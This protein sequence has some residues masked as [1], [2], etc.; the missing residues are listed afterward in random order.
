MLLGGSVADNLFQI[1]SLVQHL[2][3]LVA[4]G[5]NY[6]RNTMSSR[7]E[8][9]EWSFLFIDSISKYDLDKWNDPY[10]SK[11]TYFLEETHK[12]DIIVQIEIWATFDYYR[13]NWLVNPFNPKNNINYTTDRTKLPI[14]IPT[15]P[16]YRDN[17]FFWSVP[18]M[19]NNMKLLQYQQRF[20]DRL[21]LHTLHYPH[22]LYC[23][24]N[25]TSVTGAWG[26]FWS[27]YIKKVAE[28][29]GKKIFTTEMWD[30]WDLDHLSHRESFDHPE[31]YD[32]VEISQNN[33]QRGQQHWDNGIKQI[34]KLRRKGDY[35][36]V[37]SV[38]VYGNEEGGHGG[39]S[40]NGIE[41]F[42]R[43]VFFGASAVR[44]HRPESGLGLDPRA[45]NVI[46]GMRMV[47][48]STDF[49]SGK[50]AQTIFVGE[51][52]N[53]AYARLLED[54]STL[55]YSTQAGA[56]ELSLNEMKDVIRINLSD[57]R[58]TNL[59]KQNISNLQATEQNVVFILR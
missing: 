45:Q 17:P 52:E 42:V 48:D 9:N 18:P 54:G 24:D 34:E 57:A 55:I 11:F 27:A 49:F 47:V 22:I 3:L 46:K 29:S 33:H 15:H 20:V 39:G 28:E 43:N 10:W 5:G 6:V 58:W 12:R 2:D 30:P 37:T 40:Q 26:A 35:R 25:E 53:Q 59:G 13:D 19:D 51:M 4:S 23:M 8:G 50:P 38:K 14:S 1:D 41:S 44:F 31:V 16:V 32:F 36:P 21:L 56:L 7:N